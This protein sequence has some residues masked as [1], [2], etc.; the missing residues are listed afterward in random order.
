LFNFISNLKLQKTPKNLFLNLITYLPLILIFNFT[1]LIAQNPVLETTAI[2]NLTTDSGDN[3]V[4]LNDVITFRITV[5]NTGN[6]QLN[7]VTVT[8]NLLGLN[9]AS[10]SLDSTPVFLSSSGSSPEGTLE[11]GEIATY[12][13]TYTFNSAGVS[14][15][16][17]SLTVTSTG[18]TLAGLPTSDLGDDG[19][20][21]DGNT[22]NDP[23]QVT[24]A[25]P[26]ASIEG[27][28]LE[29][30]VD[31][32]SN[33]IV[34]LGDRM[35]YII[36]IKNTGNQTL[37]TADLTDVLKNNN[38]IT[39]V[40]IEPGVT[41]PGTPFVISDQGS[42][43]GNLLVGE[44]A[45]YKAVYVIDQDDVDSGGLNN[46]LT[47]T[48]VSVVSGA[49]VTD[50]AD[51]GDD[52]DGNLVNDCTET[53][54]TAS[55]SMEVTKVFSV[56]DANGNGLT[57]PG[58]TINYSITVLNNGNVTLSGLA[59]TET[60]K[61]GSG[62][63]L[64][65]TSGPTFV[66]NSAGSSQGTLTVGEIAT[67]SSS[68]LVT[69]NTANTGSVSNTALATASSPGQ[70][71]N[72]T[73]TSDDGDDSDG[74][75]TSDE[76]VTN[77][78]LSKALDVTKT[79]T[80][81]DNGDGV[82]GAADIINYTILV[83]NIGQIALSSITVTE[84]LVSGIGTPL[85]LNSGIQGPSSGSL[86]INQTFTF[87]S[88]YTI[89]PGDVSSGSV[90]NT[91][92][93]FGSSP[94]NSNDVSDISDDGNDL[95]GNT[96]NDATITNFATTSGLE[97][98]KT[99]VLVEASGDNLPGIGDVVVFTITVENK[100]NTSV[101][102][103][104]L[105]DTFKRGSLSDN[106]NLS[107]SSGP[108]FNSA[109]SG[110]S[111]GSLV[112]GEIATYTASYTVVSS[113]V[114]STTVY[115]SVTAN[116]VTI[117]GASISDISDDGDD[118]DGSLSSDETF[119]T[120]TQEPQ[121]EVT[122]TVVV[123]QAG[124]VIAIGDV[125]NYTITVANTG[126][127]SLTNVSISDNIQGILL[128]SALS[129]NS[130]PV[131]VSSSQSSSE[132]GLLIGEVATYTA[133]FTVNQ[134]AV[135]NNGFRNIATGSATGP[136]GT[137]VT[138]VSDNGNDSDG[139]TT[140]DPTDVVI[141]ENP[142]LEAVKVWT[143]TDNDSNS[144]LTAGD[145]INYTITVQN[146]GN[147]TLDNV[148]M[149]DDL[150]LISD[151]ATRSLATGPNFI[152]ANQ[153]SSFGTLKPNEIGTYTANYILVQDDI[154][155][156]GVKNSATVSA[157]TPANVAVTDISDDNIDNDGD[158]ESDF[159]ESPVTT[160]PSIEAMKT[161]TI[162][163]NGDGVT[164]IGD[165]VVYTLTVSNTG[166]VTLNSVTVT[167]T[168]TDMSSN[169]LSLTN[170]LTFIS[171]TKGSDSNNLLIDEAATYVATYTLDQAAFDFGGLSNSVLVAGQIFSTTVTD[172][173]DDGDDSD[174]NT[175]ND[176]TQ[177]ILTPTLLLDVTKTANVIDTDGDGE[178]GV[179]DTIV[180]T[181]SI[182]NSGTSSV[183]SFTLSDTITDAQGNA[184]S[185]TNSPV[186][187]QSG[188][189]APGAT[190]TYTATYTISQSAVDNGGVKNSVLVTASNLTGTQFTS[191]Q[192]D[193]GD[194]SDGNAVNDTTDTLI[195][196]DAKLEATKTFTSVDNDSD[197][198]IS[199]GDIVVYTIT[200]KNTGNI[201]QNFIYLED[202][203]TDFDGNARQ[204]DPFAWSNRIAFVS[205]SSSS[206]RGTLISGETA[207]YTASYTIVSGMFQVEELKTQ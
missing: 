199:V 207:T 4:G 104:T 39:L 118:N 21:T 161:S 167:D 194:D 90:S 188:N 83:K 203:I 31:L 9:N 53:S 196:A 136:N 158:I 41:P 183:A 80:V 46:C 6:I 106:S 87:T 75:T 10:L 69:V 92:S 172:T 170:S 34:S 171:A 12:T 134:V 63:N 18:Q 20:D 166:N 125:A 81:T 205:A 168:L 116:A 93:A 62:N 27:T 160:A 155:N 184:L 130:T 8:T 195:T 25:K 45:E 101:G 114:A 124:S 94:G 162:V 169:T 154:N 107:L 115:N 138:D 112:S 128:S 110:S 68:Y 57:D 150:R 16:G 149:I 77:L 19:D 142:A 146:K 179:G 36:K 109:T 79:F 187:S 180:Y 74:D 102:T 143:Y 144:T 22:I 52:T 201:T 141:P 35:E 98:T 177:N 121:I 50:Q 126:N 185:L 85:S 159:T 100:G 202:T 73:D 60:I 189:L 182:V 96:T 72:V 67:F 49:T 14:A 44:T 61:D 198:L 190:R 163:D 17:I 23:T 88:S 82:L 132:G 11:V 140:N 139:N 54:I 2:P 117:G 206:P 186:T 148:T 105:T 147:V 99:G 78:S 47:V 151:T 66:S 89:T 156:G 24:V 192:S 173:S 7:T 119:V 122:K 164:G 42:T 137:T 37:S 95:D 43:E 26:I 97:V 30:Y 70:S 153:G 145:R 58:D 178:T 174:G 123:N 59:L 13:A 108:T 38:N 76:T 181:I 193:D 131:F 5:K 29:N 40:L 175:T 133:S 200:V 51:D 197:G 135:D 191:D 120:L 71:N 129:L 91:A 165:Y 152:S 111:E 113:D 32:D 84:T 176:P 157:T 33:G 204:L 28:K 15:G 103:L 64:S 56:N 1:T 55:P 65:L 86:G 48:A 127:V 3:L